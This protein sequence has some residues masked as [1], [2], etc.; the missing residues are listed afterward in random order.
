MA[1]LWA[2]TSLA[3]AALAGGT[4]TT[5]SGQIAT[6]VSEGIACTNTQTCL[7]PH[8]APK[9]EFWFLDTYHWAAATLPNANSLNLAFCDTSGIPVL[10]MR[11]ASTGG[12][13]Q[14]EK[15]T[16]SA[17]TMLAQTPVGF[18]G[19]NRLDLHVKMAT[20]GWV[21]LYVSGALLLNFEGDT[22]AGTNRI[23]QVILG[24]GQGSASYVCRHSGFVLA[25]EDT[26]PFIF[27]QRLPTGNGAETSWTGDYTAVDET[28]VNDADFISSTSPNDLETFTFN[29][30]PGAFDNNRLRGVVLSGRTNGSG[31]PGNIRGVA[32]VGGV[33]YD[34]PGETDTTPT[35]GPQQ[36]IFET[37]PATGQ[38]WLGS[39][40]N[41]S[42]F[43]V[44]SI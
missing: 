10:R 15:W 32:R 22:S 38:P 16:G 37:N 27:Y 28:G 18:T 26:R 14:I 23:N 19:R 9:D 25:D 6:T 41:S 40:V 13:H 29:A 21:R 3:D 17:W 1:I 12:V 8:V 31:S 34:I 33:N 30:L 7:S 24:S 5:D 43:G 39:E 42:Q 44:K 11:L 35:Y 2:G 36:W 20:S 4:L